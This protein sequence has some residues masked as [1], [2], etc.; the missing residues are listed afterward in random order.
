MMISS[1][2]KVTAGELLVY[3]GII[4]DKVTAGGLLVYDGIIR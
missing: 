4:V 2:D 1:V 3:D